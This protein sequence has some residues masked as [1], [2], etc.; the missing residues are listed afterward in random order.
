MASHVT[1][2][3]HRTGE[4]CAS[5]AIRNV[6]DFHGI[7]LSEP[8][9]FGLSSGLGFHY[10]ASDELSPTRMFHG[11]TAT[12]ETDFHE[13]VAIPFADQQEPDDG[14]AWDALRRELDAGNPV[15]I[16]TDTYYLGYQNTTSHFPGHRCVVVGYDG[17]SETVQIADRRFDE[18]QTC[19]FDELR[20]SRNA[21]DYPMRC[22]NQYARFLGEVKL[23]RRL[24]DAIRVAL[25]R[26]AR[27]ML[28]PDDCELPSGIPAMRRLADELPHWG[29]AT[30]WSWA[31]R[32]GYQ[33][34]ERRGAGGSFFR[35]LE[36]DF[37]AEAAPRVPEL[38]RAGLP[39]AMREIAADWRALAAVLKEQ[40]ERETCD[41]ILFA[42]AGEKVG[43]LADREQHF[44]ERVRD[45]F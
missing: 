39:A 45:L 25:R 32:F 20:R 41:P 43:E 3:R 7:Q 28:D 27:H 17:A 33:I 13:N 14:R 36:A 37:L 5:T 35:S 44:F 19:G 29:A 24:D 8:M 30:D 38:E 16:S 2:Y 1:G 26:N 21:P 4:H 12:L 42:R 23:G 34:V 18:P 9:I 6:L 15:M 31:A 22:N 10:L 11:R 40:S